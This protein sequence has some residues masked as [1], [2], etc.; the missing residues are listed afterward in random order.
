MPKL[1]GEILL[2]G[3]KSISHRAALFSA[4]RDGVSY[5]ENF[6][7]N[8][9]CLATV[10]CLR[11]LSI[12]VE[13]R[14]HGKVT[15]HGKSLD[16]WQKPQHDLNA[17]NSGTTARLLSALLANLKFPTRL[18]GDA[19]LS[20]RPMK[21]IIEPLTQMG[22][23]I[24]S[25]DGYLPLAFEPVPKLNGIT[26]QLPVASAQV[27]SAVLLAGLFAEGKTTVI[28]NLT[29]RDHTER[30]LKLPI[31]FDEQGRK[32]IFSWAGL[33]VP[34]ISMK[35]PGDF[36]SAAFFMVGSLL[37]PGSRLNIR[38]VSLNP[39]RTGFL[40]VLELM[41][42]EIEINQLQQEP[43]PAGDISIGWQ[44]LHN[45]EIPKELVPNIIDE[46]P[47][48]A[49][50]AVRSEG[51]MILHH[52][53]ELR[54]KES[55][56][57]KAMVENLRHLGVQCEEFEDG[58]SISGPQQFKGGKIKTYGD[59]RIAM[60]FAIANLVSDEPIELDDPACVAVSFPNFF[61]ILKKVVKD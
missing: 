34:D 47:I 59:H 60:S 13:T 33:A 61:E 51:M 52:A 36:S 29:S 56:R 30:L 23:K 50:L 44:A 5:F 7:F 26:F 9:D 39:T 12:P 10:Q 19:S 4:F 17:E 14:E 16:D 1:K 32:L 40:K 6:N 49:I 18:I 42:A 25:N 8:Q 24:K 43:E 45:I 46:I 48:L 55:D 58:F 15:I 31:D 20:R 35:I 28:E 22:A 11:A 38:N 2:P 54:F 57:I 41:G 27:K 21:R 3:D 37:L 53:R